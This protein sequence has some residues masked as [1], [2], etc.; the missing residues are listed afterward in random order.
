MKQKGEKGWDYFC[1]SLLAFG[2]LGLEVL[3]AFVIEPMFF[4]T[5]MQNWSSTQN[6]IHWIATCTVWGLVAYLLVRD[7]KRNLNF[8]IFQVTAKPSWGQWIG[9]VACVILSLI[10]SYL[11]W[12]GFKVLKEFAYNG[13]L[14]FIFQYIYYVFETVLFLL[15]I[16]FGQQAFEKWFKH[17]GFPYGGIV[18]ALT[19]GLVHTLTKGDLIVGVTCAAGGLLYGIVYL[20]A[21]RNVRIAFPVLVIMFIL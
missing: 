17:S 1:L 4:K 3:L 20:L 12:D 18:V 10:I 15:I 11:S 7:A 13:W 14:K 2:G 8:S 5:P 9:I 6:V 19:W 21:N 16:V